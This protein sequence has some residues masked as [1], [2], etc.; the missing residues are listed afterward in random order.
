MNAKLNAD[1]QSFKERLD[2]KGLS[3]PIK[4]GYLA[5]YRQIW[6]AEQM[7]E[8]ELIKRAKMIKP[9]IRLDKTNQRYV[10]GDFQP[11]DKFVFTL[12]CDI[13]QSYLYNY[14]KKRIV[15]ENVPELQEVTSFTCYHRYG[16]Y[17]GF[18]RPGVNEVLSQI[19]E[20]INLDEIQAFEIKIASLN[21][22]SLYDDVLD[23]HVTTVIL[24]KMKDGLPKS[25]AN[26][27]VICDGK[28]Y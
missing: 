21:P 25:M 7:S 24:Y 27:K 3:E 26:Q 17:F 13:R 16:G 11:G 2:Q 18:F 10:A 28:E 5:L 22:D 14:A 23:R 9:L 4:L 1:L 20:D 6:L 15:P 8:T 12:P 19:P